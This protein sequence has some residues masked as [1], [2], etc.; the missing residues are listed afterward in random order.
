VQQVRNFRYV[1]LEGQGKVKIK[2]WSKWNKPK[3]VR[4]EERLCQSG[5]NKLS[6]CL[7]RNKLEK[8]RICERGRSGGE[9]R[10]KSGESPDRSG[11]PD[12]SLHHWGN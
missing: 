12:F 5:K 10:G 7:K 2:V 9:K 3:G 6:M 4:L 11:N 1:G 8:M